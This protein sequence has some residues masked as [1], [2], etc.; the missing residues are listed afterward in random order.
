MRPRFFVVPPTRP[1]HLRA[2]GSSLT[3]PPR[4]PQTPPRSPQTPRDPSPRTRQFPKPPQDPP[5][6]PQTPP[7]SPQ[8]PRDPSP[9][10]RPPPPPA[11]GLE[12][13]PPRGPRRL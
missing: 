8:T 3:D 6:D 10:T 4:D 2:D 7:R 9:R 12:L 11:P 1:S 13:C 5:R